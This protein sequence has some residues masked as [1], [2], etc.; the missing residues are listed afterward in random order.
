MRRL[1]TWALVI[2]LVALAINEAGSYLS[3]LYRLDKASHEIAITASNVARGNTRDTQ[4]G[5][6]AAMAK[7]AEL[8]VTV[9]GY[10]ETS[11]QVRVWTKAPVTGSWVI[12]PVRTWL[13]ERG[14]STP[15]EVH[16]RDVNL[17]D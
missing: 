11:E 17:I 1:F 16:R 9:R 12:G 7:A 2:G 3:A 5:G 8:G 10:E 15:Y 4:A 14:R 13:T 6:R